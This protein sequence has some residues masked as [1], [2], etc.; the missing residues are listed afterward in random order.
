VRA[1]YDAP[2][3]VNGKP[4]EEGRIALDGRELFWPN[5]Q[6]SRLKR[7]WEDGWSLRVMQHVLE[8]EAIECFVML[9][10][11]LAQGVLRSRYNG[12]RGWRKDEEWRDERAFERS[13]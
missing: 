9:F 13:A 10:D 5:S 4:A 12:W 3:F 11:L 1:E 8:R 7:L 6:I 2:G